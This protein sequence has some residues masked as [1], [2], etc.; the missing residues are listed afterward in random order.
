MRSW[1]AR[2]WSTG[3]GWTGAMVGVVALGLVVWSMRMVDQ[4]IPG[5]ALA[6]VWISLGDVLVVLVI[7]LLVLLVCTVGARLFKRRAP[8]P[9]L[10]ALVASTALLA[11]MSPGPSPLGWV[12]IALIAVSAGA[13]LGSWCATM[14]AVRTSSAAPPGRVRTVVT[15]LVAV[16]VLVTTAAL[17]WPGAAPTEMAPERAGGAEFDPSRPGPHA[18][19]TFSYGSG[20]TEGAGRYGTEVDVVSDTLD[21]AQMLPEWQA[22]S[23]RTRVWGFDAS[24]L[25]V[26]AAVWAPEDDGEFP[27]VLIVHGNAQHDRSELGFDYVAEQ[28][29]G[30]GYVVASID[31][32]FLN[33]GPLDSG[34]GLANGDQVRSLLVLQHLEQWFQWSEQDEGHVPAADLQQVVLLGH[35]RGGE[36]VT[37]AAAIGAG[38]VSPDWAGGPTPAVRIASVVALAP[39]DGL[40]LEE[41]ELSGIDYLTIAGTHDADVSTF[42]G[43]RQYQRIDPGPAGFKAAVLLHRANHS[44]FNSRWGRYDVAAGL[45]GRVLN[46]G[47]LL[48]PAQQ[49]EVTAAL[50]TAFLHASLEG[51]DQAREVFTEPL[52]DA[53]WLPPEEVRVTVGLG[54]QS[55]REDFAGEQPGAVGDSGLN[56][57]VGDLTIGA[58]SAE[59]VDLPSRLGP[60]GNHALQVQGGEGAPS[61]EFTPI[62][63]TSDGRFALDVA[64]ASPVGVQ[65]GPIEVRVEAT[66]ESGERA[67]CDLGEVGPTLDGE[68]GKVAAAMPL[69]PGEPYLSTIGAPIECF[70]EAGLDATAPLQLT[71]HLSGLGAD[72]AYL[73]N[74]GFDGS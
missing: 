35:S 41:P 73:D 71:V 33:T 44:Q 62:Q 69:P 60:S 67:T 17:V 57:A 42:A 4:A 11:T 29:A 14:L 55:E 63:W 21:A 74:V 34:G 7:A 50:V 8:A 26:N 52:P 56:T 49:Q 10:A 24:A 2:Y 6:S 68:L 40:I 27:L 19:R 59:I 51:S 54:R 16:L 45:S 61:V 25:P 65:A 15:G 31:Q 30:H 66:D 70:T 47:A 72:G 43:A 22:D 32:S 28:L 18:V 1:L 58:G 5:A 38:E 48:E 36:A 37:A 3:P 64:D 23:T 20:D 53:G 46:R 12:W 13:V 39:S 9:A